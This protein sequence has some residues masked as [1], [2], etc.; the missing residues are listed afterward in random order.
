MKKF[1]IWILLLL[2]TILLF[3][4]AVRRGCAQCLSS[5]FGA[6]LHLDSPLLGRGGLR[7]G[8]LGG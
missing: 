3:A 5:V 7:A 8:F 2:C 4:T 6:I 1:S